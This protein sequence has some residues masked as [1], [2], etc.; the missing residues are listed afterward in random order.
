[1]IRLITLLI[2]VLMFS[3]VNSQTLLYSENFE[4]NSLPDSVTSAG[5]ATWAKSSTL[6][7]QGSRSDSS[8]IIN[9]GDTSVLTTFSF[10]TLGNSFVMLH[11]DHICKIE[12]FD[13]AYIEVSNNNGTTWTRLTGAQYQGT[14]QFATQGDKFTA[15]AY[16]IDW[17]AGSYAVPSNA[18]W[19][20]EV[21]DISLLVGNAANVKV[22][23]VLRDATPG[24]IMPDNYAWFIDN[25][26]VIGAFSE[27]NPPILTML[28]PIVQDTVYS[29][30]PY[31]VRAHITDQSL[32]DTAYVVYWV[33]TG[34]PDTIGMNRL[35]AD[36]FRAYIPFFGFG[37][38]IHYYVV[39]VDGSAA[40][41]ISTS[42]TYSFYCKFST[43]GT[44]I[45]GTATNSNSTTVYP[46]PYGNWYYGAKHQFL[47]LAS[48]L[49]ALGAPG[50]AI[51]SLAFNVA[52]AQGIPLQGFYIKMGHT[53]QTAMTTNMITNL[54]QV[55][56]VTAYTDVPGWNTHTFQTPFVWNGVDNLVV[57]VC[58][59]NS[60]YT[61]NAMTYYTATPF[62][63]CVWINQDASGVCTQTSAYSTSQ[64]RPNMKIEILG[65]SSLTLDAGVGQIVYP[66]GGVV[67]N[68][69]FNVTA[70]VKNFGTDTLTS[71]TINWKLDGV[72]Q[73]PFA[74]TGSLLKDSL[75]SVVTLGSL[76][77]PV[78]V[79][80]ILA[81]TDN[82][83]G[84]PDLNTGNDSATISF[85]ACASLLAGTYTIG[86]TNP[87][88]VDFNAAIIALAQCGISA[89]V[90]FNVAPGTYN[91]QITIPWISGTSPINTITFQAANNDSTSVILQH[92]AINVGTNWVVKLMGA[93]YITLKNLKIAPG[94]ATFANA[95]I[96]SDGAQYNTIKGCFIVGKP[97]STDDLVVVKAYGANNGSNLIQGNR[98]ESGSAAIH[99]K[100][101]SSASRV[102]NITVDG[103]VILDFANAGIKAEFTDGFIATKN[104][105]TSAVTNT[106]QKEGIYLYYAYIQPQVT[107]NKVTLSGGYNT[108]GINLE[109]CTLSLSSQALIANNFVSILNGA[110]NTFGI[111]IQYTSYAKVFHNSLYVFGNSNIATRGINP[112]GTCSNITVLNNIVECNY[113]PMLYEGSAVVRS[114]FNNYY[115]ST[116][117]YGY[118]T[119]SYINF[120]SLDALK[121]ATQKDTNSV[122]YIPY[123]TSTSDLH[124]FN[125]LLNGIATPVPEVTDDI[126]GELRDLLNPDPGADEFTPSPYD[127]AVLTILTAVSGC[128][129]STTSDVTIQIKN[130]G[131]ATISGGLT[132]YYQIQGSSTVV[133]EQVTATIVSPN[134]YDYTFTTKANFYVDSIQ[135]DSVFHI[136]AWVSLTGDI[137]Q[138]NDTAKAFFTSSF[139]P[140]HPLVSDTTVPFGSV[141]QL[142]AQSPWTVYWYDSASAQTG[143]ATGLSY[144]T[145]ILYMNTTYWLESKTTSYID[146]A[147]NVGSQLSNYVAS[148]TR[149]YHFTAP[150]DM[151]IMELM[152]PVTV[153]TGGQYIQVVKFSGYPLNYPSGSQFTTLAY[154]ANA[155]FGVPQQVNIPIQAGDEIGIIGA[156][157][158][159]G[160]TMSNSY[161]P[162]NVPS[163][164]DGYPITL[165]RLV[166]QNPLSTGAA[167][168]GSIGL[169]TS[170]SIARVEMTYR[171]GAEGCPSARVPLNVIVGG[172]PPLDLS[173]VT[174]NTPVT[175]FDL[176][177]AEPVNITLANNGT[178]A[179]SNFQVGYSIN[180]GLPVVETVTSTMAPSSTMNYT[181]SAPANLSLYQVYNI[182]AFAMLTGD[183]VPVNDTA[184]KTVENKMLIFCIST[185]TSTGYE[186]ITNVTVNTMSNTSM[187]VGSMY[188]DFTQ[189]VPPTVLAPGMTYPISVT[190]DYPPGYSYPYSCWVKAWIDFDHD[191]VFD[192]VNEMVFSSATTS[193]N[194]VTGSFT[195]PA[196][197]VTGVQRLRVVFVETSSA[198][199]VNPCGTYSWG[200]TEDY[201][202]MIAPNIP[203]DAGVT[204]IVTPNINMFLTEG[205]TLPVHVEIKNFGTTTLT[206]LSVAYSVNNGPPVVTPFTNLNILQYDVDTVQLPDMI[207]PPGNFTICAYTILAGDSNTFNDMTCRT[208]F[209]NP[210]IDLTTYSLNTV[211]DGCDLGMDTIRLCFK[212]I[213]GT[214]IPG[215][216]TANYQVNGGTVVTEP[217]TL[218][219]NPG[220]S[221]C[222]TFTTLHNFAV[223]TKDSVFTIKA[224]AKH[225][226]DG[227]FYND[228]VTK[229]VT[230]LHTPP[231]PIAPTVTTPYGTSG[232]LTVTSSTND[233]ILWY[234]TATGG[235]FFHIGSTYTTG[236]LYSD[237]TLYV[238]AVG[239]IPLQTFTLGTGTLQNSQYGYPTPYGNYYWGNKEQYIIQAPELLGLGM[240]AGE[241]SE[242][243]FDVAVPGNVPLQ[244]YTIK[245]GNT[246]QTTAT[247]AFISSGLQT[248]YYASTYTDISGWNTHVFQNGFQWDG[249]SNVVVEVCFNNSS[250]IING[251]V[252]QTA[253]PFPATT[254]YNADQPTVCGTATAW[255]TYNQRPNIRFVA[256]ANGCA[257]ARVPLHV[258][259]SGQQAC[260]VGVSTILEPVT[261]VNLGTQENVKVRITNYGTAPQS[262]F[263]VSYRVNA[264][265]PVTETI[266]A[267]IPA[268]GFLD[269]SFVAKANLGIV[270][271]TYQVKAWTNLSCDGT[272]Q[273]DTSWKSMTNLFPAYC[274]S[275][276]T[277]PGY[278]DLT[279]VTIHTLNNTSAAVGSMYT[280]FTAT[281]QAPMLSPGMSY[282]MSIS[283]GFPPG[284]SYQYPCWVKAWIDFNRDGVLDPVNEMVFSSATTSSNTVTG[285]VAIPPGALNGNTLMRVVFVET[286]SAAYVTPCGTYSWG[287]TEDYLVTI[288]PQSACDAGIVAVLQ[289]GSTTQAGASLPVQ[290]RFMNFGS[291]PIQAG[292]L[293]IAYKLNN[294]NPVV[295][296]Y[297]NSMAPLD[298]ASIYLPNITVAMGNNTL[299]VYTILACDSSTFND[300][301]CKNI[302]GHYSTT[303]PFFDDF[304]S[305][306]LWYRPDGSVNWQYGTPSA[307][308]I[309]NAYSGIKAWVTNL[310][311]DY[312]N[313][314]NDYIYSPSFDFSGLGATDTV[315]LSF[316]H[317]CDMAANDFGH[318]QYTLDGGQNWSNLGFMGDNLGVNWYNAQSGGTHFF[319][320]YNSGWMYSAF[321]LTP[322]PFNLS[323]DV[324]FRFRFSSNTSVTA[325]GWAIDN[326]RLAL[327]QV[328]NDVGVT[329][330]NY[331]VLDTAIG[332][333]VNATVTITNFGTNPQ[334]NIPVV[335]KL[336]GAAVSTGTWTGTL[337]SQA[338]ATYQ[339]A[340]PFTVPASSYQLCAETQLP[341]DAFAVNNGKCSNYYPQPA[342][343]DVGVMRIVKPLPDSVG[344]IC[345][346][347][348]QAQPWYH[349][350][351]V[352]RIRNTGQN[353]QTSVP[354]KYRFSTG[355]TE[356]T[357]TWTGTLVP[358]DSVDFTL[359]NQFL[360]ALGAQQVCIETVLSGDPVA[361]ND[362][363]CLSYTG[364][365]CI[366]INDPAGS[367][368]VLYQ[369][370]PNPARGTTTIG[371]KVPVSGDVTFGLV[372]MLGQV[373]HS[374][375]HPANPGENQI[376]LDVSALA[377]GVYYYFIEF[378]G[379]RLSKK[380]IIRN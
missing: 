25:I 306:N 253:T 72:L 283:S 312:G 286:S 313:N 53:S 244:G 311:G 182:K 285:N 222:Y 63:S 303:L 191:A 125:G 302:F 118:Y 365:A 112:T 279:N 20:S 262:N 47:I 6:F 380:L 169:E 156:S 13:E 254:Q 332:S 100:G 290:V 19:K 374:G 86:G 97:G 166:Y 127:A 153:N 335:L 252:N 228:T 299:C 324:Q 26:R 34:A 177:A 92:T 360:P 80:T 221:A 45:V 218:S 99:I 16:A 288:A 372:G 325:N 173:V 21:F 136:M 103:N 334:T 314:A 231:S 117:L 161:G 188:T 38:N 246:T 30:G 234:T 131:S 35:L 249:S 77:L 168:S 295:V 134:T 230:S 89:P 260:D 199:Y 238:E 377:A 81:W 3:V 94:S 327:P 69:P 232:V 378:N 308:V 83:N 330:I 329:S 317:W 319:S 33:N 98:I 373:I 105:V 368:F 109:Q 164:I 116:N 350:D 84:Q 140:Y 201:V 154:I 114:N 122:S 171:I 272:H 216:I 143:I 71:V 115:S 23:F 132:A 179:I 54:T 181:F 130:A 56:S 359:S 141:V 276:A 135:M 39:A 321:K 111:R 126:D 11:F 376:E 58:F 147:L 186:D 339:F 351:V 217:L 18:W 14:S 214:Q 338:T 170:S 27:L 328:P 119:S 66:T 85:M 361:S 235:S 357:D 41:N 243:S 202:V 165:R 207:C 342:Q 96:L 121:L 318:V 24:S 337:A 90:V 189:S 76:T 277:S 284:Y 343:N 293:S 57:E 348:Q 52:S 239:A 242:L 278:E 145:P 353:P 5:T 157:N 79:H 310:T 248:V 267:T 315:T 352:V 107:K 345:F 323:T 205:D 296:P 172:A 108:N 370:V 37:K 101:V 220:D 358:N 346:Y 210:Q 28:P 269:Y 270:G 233:T 219:M 331:P 209:G 104:I 64:D 42:S 237:T 195:V 301:I 227:V 298:T 70:R 102:A 362:K 354:V 305:S 10:S 151:T 236:T 375:T 184:L 280:D 9:P 50:G 178:Q 160:T 148:Q 363:S 158:P 31:M 326:F 162:A 185:A 93:Q 307:N 190:T 300:E 194:T 340:N 367:G 257:S 322:N 229:V 356:Y 180:G 341:G 364:K 245:M 36:T 268:N 264:S 7:S 256:G 211:A 204:T 137:L 73:T 261:A 212:H 224:W 110:N 379:Q 266:T 142:S 344:N 65:V 265:A 32:V 273:N 48:E 82:P 251:V 46:A 250:Y 12:F 271:S 61:Y 51:G 91:G 113:Y 55:Y 43:G 146:T 174:I 292:A 183:A 29:T 128:G 144:T 155:P 95:I 2:S 281:V 75:S 203:F 124:T 149:G 287:E 187:A 68:S 294:G 74:W 291:N 355:G 336:N 176:T 366:G 320:M 44:F 297:P 208:L 289:P 226:G 139:A 40:H 215:G 123:F 17:A 347:H 59:N 259:V 223:T 309:N 241:I 60:S 200:E 15:A 213:G 304:E 67:A 78:G 316:Y 49:V 240:V 371:Y 87:D 129:Y 133:S 106:G 62:T 282:T 167:A 255:S 159:S 206:S 198:M 197:A 247:T 88:F 120:S 152:V 263:T 274:I 138:A 22:R 225:A 369:N 8:R 196:N 150:V 163:S 4:T 192:P 175:N 349:F 275:T 333:L 193:S 1:M 258:I